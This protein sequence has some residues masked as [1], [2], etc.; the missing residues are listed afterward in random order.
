LVKPP[1]FYKFALL[2]GAFS[3][4]LGLWHYSISVRHGIIIKLNLTS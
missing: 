4:L 3:F 1:R 2:S